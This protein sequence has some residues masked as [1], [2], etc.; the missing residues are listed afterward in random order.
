MILVPKMFLTACHR[1]SL[2]PG[3]GGGGLTSANEELLLA[4]F[5]EHSI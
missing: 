3:T 5:V 4:R 2:V 1:L